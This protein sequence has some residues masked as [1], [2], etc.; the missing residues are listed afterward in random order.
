MLVSWVRLLDGRFRDPLVGR[1]VFFGLVAGSGLQLLLQAWPLAS[2]WWGI[3]PPV[4]DIPPYWIEFANLTGL[5]FAFANLVDLTVAS[6]VFTAGYIVSLLLLRAVLKKQ[7]LAN[8]AFVLVWSVTGAWASANPY[9]AFAFAAASTIVWLTV[10]LRFGLLTSLVAFSV[11]GLLALYPLT[12]DFRHWY[13]ASTILVLVVVAGLTAYG[14]RVALA[15]RT[16]LGDAGLER[17]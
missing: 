16:I 14:F 2:R 1:D 12:F 9:V 3:A 6:F 11:Q 5:R 17:P 8:A 15:G 7:W 4:L 13:A 10:L